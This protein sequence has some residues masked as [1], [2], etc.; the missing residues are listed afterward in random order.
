MILWEPGEVAPGLHVLADAGVPS[1]LLDAEKSLL[2]DAGFACMGP[3]Y[4]TEIRR[5]L[6]GR[7]PAFLL[8]THS[9][10]DHCGSAS[11]L[12]GEFPGMRVGASPLAAKVF[13]RPTAMETIRFLNEN[14]ARMVAEAKGAE[15]PDLACG[16]IALDLELSGGD[17]IQAGPGMTVRVL[18]T[19]GHT[20]D[21][22]SFFLPEM[23]A[24][25]CSEAAGIPDSTGA[26]ICDYLVDYDLFTASV[27]KLAALDL[28]VIC[29]G[30]AC[31]LTG[32][33]ARSYLPEVLRQC[34]ESKD[35]FERLLAEEHGDE[36]RVTARVRALEYDPKPFPKQPEP[37]Y[38]LNLAARIA[39][40]KKRMGG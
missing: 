3:L 9:H 12:A 20:R 40:M 5:V 39:V 35:M 23:K 17:E 8:L 36:E 15:V 31:V 13:S 7:S 37:A 25:V 18:E 6:G 2:F 4:A 19:P 22:L 34:Q 10:F 38:L 16:D 32:G 26:I 28:D 1:F 21:C 11:Y 24:L 29:L 30:H 14:A 33:D 27:E